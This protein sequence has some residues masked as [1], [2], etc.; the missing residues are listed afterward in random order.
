MSKLIGRF[1]LTSSSISF[2]QPCLKT[3]TATKPPGGTD[4]TRD[5]FMAEQITIFCPNVQT[6]DF[7]V[8]DRMMI[9]LLEHLSVVCCYGGPGR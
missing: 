3:L 1:W 5:V 9:R 2:C 7:K 6:M 4:F 8:D